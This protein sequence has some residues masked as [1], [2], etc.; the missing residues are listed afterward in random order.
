MAVANCDGEG[1]SMVSRAQQVVR[2]KKGSKVAWV[3]PTF[4]TYTR[5]RTRQ[6][7]LGQGEKGVHRTLVI[8]CS[9][10]DIFPSQTVGAGVRDTGTADFLLLLLLLQP[11]PFVV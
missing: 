4:T 2:M 7:G 10:V 11:P 6:V 5:A 3:Y 8:V 1:A 9:P